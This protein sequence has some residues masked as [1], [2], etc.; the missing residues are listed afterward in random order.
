[1]TH[2]EL[3]SELEKR[4]RQLK[5][6]DPEQVRFLEG[7]IAK[8][9][10]ELADKEAETAAKSDMKAEKSPGK[11]KKGKEPS[12]SNKHYIEINEPKEIESNKVK[13]EVAKL[14]NSKV[15][16][17]DIL[18]KMNFTTDNP[19]AIT[20]KFQ[21]IKNEAAFSRDK[22]EDRFTSK[23]KAKP[24][25]KVGKYSIVEE[26]KDEQEVATNLKLKKVKDDVYTL[27]H[28]DKA[29][30]D[31]ERQNGRWHVKCR[32]DG[33][34]RKT[35]FATLNGAVIYV[36]KTVYSAEL[37]E[38]IQAKKKA[39]KRAKDWRE[40]NPE[41]SP[42]SRDAQGVE[43]AAE[44]IVEKAEE[45]KGV[46]SDV[47]KV[48]STLKAPVKEFTKIA[49]DIDAETEKEIDALISELQ[50]LKAKIK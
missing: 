19:K 31:F 1:M 23:F 48:F 34:N 11:E 27:M 10:A 35:G 7:K 45:G 38:Y 25:D 13:D 24:G 3:K 26:G 8:L 9:K 46:T 41:G 22:K 36:S 32:V 18:L 50:K 15:K 28:K 37:R 17:S 30:F 44:K 43:K 39:A 40:K 42:P 14:V 49:K 33:N 16:S 47:K 21:V 2:A 29:A 4:E 20:D 5:N 12:K 6:A